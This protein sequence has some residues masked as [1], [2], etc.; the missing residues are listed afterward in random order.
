MDKE[1]NQDFLNTHS[2]PNTSLNSDADAE[3][4]SD[5]DFMIG[6]QWNNQLLEEI[7]DFLNLR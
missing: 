5:S 2:P 1:N 4:D 7:R 3:E 6:G